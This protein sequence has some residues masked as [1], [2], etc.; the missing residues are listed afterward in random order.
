MILTRLTNCAAILIFAASASVVAQER[1][2][3]LPPQRDAYFYTPRNKL[4][5]FESRE[6]TLLIKVSRTHRARRVA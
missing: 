6:S 2:Q 3:R 1:W 4:E 5:E